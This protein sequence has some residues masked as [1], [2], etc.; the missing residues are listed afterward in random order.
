MQDI[1][2]ALRGAAAKGGVPNIALDPGELRPA[3]RADDV[4]DL[5]EV[6]E[7]SGGKVVQANDPLVQAQELLGQMGADETGHAGDQPGG[8]GG[9]QMLLQ[10]VEF[11]HSSFANIAETDDG[12]FHVFTIPNLRVDVARGE[13]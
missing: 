5:G 7:V 4:A 12:N 6:L 13:M 1:V 2:G 3:R 10:L 11:S 9:G 8:G